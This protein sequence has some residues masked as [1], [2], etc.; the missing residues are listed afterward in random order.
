MRIFNQEKTEEIT[1]ETIDFELGYLKDDRIF[2]SRH[3]AIVGKTSEELAKELIVQ[4]EV[5]NFRQDG[6][7]YRQIQLYENGGSLEE[8]IYPIEPKQEWDEYE[9]IRVFVPYTEEQIKENRLASFR[10]QREEKCFSII[11]RGQLWY[12]GLT[13]QQI[14][15]LTA[16]YKDWLNVTQTLEVPSKPKWLK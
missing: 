1:Q 16:W 13:E 8:I 14:A 15:E 7:W 12:D 5:C 6:N 9:N 2:V 4:G 10:S 3:K 11:N